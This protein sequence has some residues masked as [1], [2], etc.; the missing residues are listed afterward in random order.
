MNL[1]DLLAHLAKRPQDA[2]KL[3]D[4]FRL[5]SE[6]DILLGISFAACAKDWERLADYGRAMIQTVQ[7]RN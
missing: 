5:S 3:C 1:S 2:Q 4:D 7:D 6:G